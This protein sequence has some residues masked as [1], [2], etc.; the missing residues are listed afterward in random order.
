MSSIP[1]QA[2][3][4]LRH[5]ARVQFRTPQNKPKKKKTLNM[6][7]CIMDDLAYSCQ[8]A[9]GSNHGEPKSNSSTTKKIEERGRE[10]ST[11]SDVY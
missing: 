5:A 1:L 3:Y 9:R 6:L 4:V 7:L 10:K 2:A 11:I 8:A